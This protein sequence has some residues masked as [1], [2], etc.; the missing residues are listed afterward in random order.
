MSTSRRTFMKLGAGVLA[1]CFLSR[2]QNI[3]MAATSQLS[4]EGANP[5]RQV[6]LS[7]FN[8]EDFTGDEIS[9]PHDVLW[10]IDGYIEKKGGLPEVSAEYDVVIV[11]GGMAGLT[12]AY[13]LRD[14]KVL[15]LEQSPHLGG[16]SQGEIY[17]NSAYSIGAAYIVAP[18]EGSRSEQMLADIGVLAKG[19]IETAESTSVLY[20]QDVIPSFWQNGVQ[21]KDAEATRKVFDKLVEIRDHWNLEPDSEQGRALNKISFEK[22]LSTELPDC[23]VSVKEYFQLYC[24]SSF[25]ASI[26]EVAA[27]NMLSFVSDETKALMAF[28]GG[29]GAISEG[30]Y[31]RLRRDLPQGHIQNNAMVMRV[32]AQGDSAVVLFEDGLGRLLRV[33]AKAVVM[34]C[35]KFVAKRLLPQMPAEQGAAIGKVRYRAYL[36]A[37]IIFKTAFKSSSFELYCLKGQVPSSPTVMKPPKQA[38]TDICFGSWAQDDQV[39]HGILTLYKGLPMDGTR[40]FLFNPDS[41]QKFKRQVMADLPYVLEGLGLKE[42]DILGLRLTRWGHALP[43]AAVGIHSDGTMEKINQPIQGRIFFANQDNYIDP[44]FESSVAA[45]QETAD[46]VRQLL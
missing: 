10:N 3:A 40:Q 25:C 38:F 7:Q 27:S 42:A 30:L 17:G 23:P 1:G 15:L 26:D 11:G 28:P 31:R 34:S 24:W 2:H 8:T 18:E 32:E 41:H 46:E 14:K 37:N 43:L 22:W 13:E 19:K 33:R 4:L 9:K 20:H 5:L 21:G 44:C 6:S 39:D 16:N 45:A 12:T 35:P 36:V 29:N